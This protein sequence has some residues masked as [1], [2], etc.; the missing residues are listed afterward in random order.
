M[1]L[2]RRCFM[3]AA[4]LPLCYAQSHDET[5]PYLDNLFWTTAVCHSQRWPSLGTAWLSSLLPS[6]CLRS[7]LL[8][9]LHLR[10]SRCLQGVFQLPS[11]PRETCTVRERLCSDGRA[12]VSPS[13]KEDL[14]DSAAPCSGSWEV[15]PCSR[16]GI[17]KLPCS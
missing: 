5:F 8:Q 7:A 11:G 16:C 2:H 3:R 1:R 14:G 15:L 10:T 13:A 17:W 4:L 6:P 9:H 12:K